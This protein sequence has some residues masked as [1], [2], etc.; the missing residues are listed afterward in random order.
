[1]QNSQNDAPAGELNPAD[2]RPSFNRVNY[3]SF[4]DLNDNVRLSPVIN[5]VFDRTEDE[6]SFI[7]GD[8]LGRRFTVG[9]TTRF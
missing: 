2:V 7:M 9:V 3:S 5:N 1:M 6:A 4:Y 8:V